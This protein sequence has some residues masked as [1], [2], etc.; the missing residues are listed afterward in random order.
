ME[1]NK[2]QRFE[3]NVSDNQ[4][5]IICISQTGYVRRCLPEVLQAEI[6]ATA[7]LYIASRSPA[8]ATTVLNCLVDVFNSTGYLDRNCVAAV[9][10]CG[11]TLRRRGRRDLIVSG[12]ETFFRFLLRLSGTNSAGTF[13][14]QYQRTKYFNWW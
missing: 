13:R 8:H 1:P 11:Y 6:C 12:G 10:I 4:V 7:Q 14:L 3:Y 9:A 5:L 2:R